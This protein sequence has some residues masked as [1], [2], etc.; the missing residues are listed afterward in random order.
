MF[1]TFLCSF[2]NYFKRHLFLPKEVCRYLLEFLVGLRYLT[3][4]NS[5][6]AVLLDSHYGHSIFSMYLTYP[7]SLTGYNLKFLYKQIFRCWS[8]TDID[9]ESSVITHLKSWCWTSGK[10]SL[11]IFWNTFYF[12]FINYTFKNNIAIFPVYRDQVMKHTSYETH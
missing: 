10:S 12:P 11:N 8:S 4:T 2:W 1:R 9:C 7:Y 5:V 3:W 6:T